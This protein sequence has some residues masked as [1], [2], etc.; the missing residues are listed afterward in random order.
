MRSYALASL[1]LADQLSPNI[2]GSAFVASRSQ[3]EPD[4]MMSSCGV[5]PDLTE[6]RGDGL[7]HFD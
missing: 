1:L 3:N 6:L 5:D 4:S 2:G 7:A